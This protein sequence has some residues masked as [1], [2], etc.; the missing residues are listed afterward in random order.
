VLSYAGE[1]EVVEPLSLRES[2]I[3]RLYSM[4]DTYGL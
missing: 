4:N 2:L 3:K 1:I